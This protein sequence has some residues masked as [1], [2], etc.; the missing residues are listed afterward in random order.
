MKI[1][2][3]ISSVNSKIFDCE[4]VFIICNC[5]I[6]FSVVVWKKNSFFL[7][8]KYEIYFTSLVV[9]STIWDVVSAFSCVRSWICL[10]SSIRACSWSCS[11]NFN[12]DCTR[13]TNKK[14]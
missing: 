4:F 2:S 12:C 9:N 10:L 5:F 1:N 3:T 8:K 11:T 7:I 14:Q 13:E 6:S